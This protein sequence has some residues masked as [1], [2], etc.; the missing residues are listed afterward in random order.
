[1]RNGPK[2][3]NVAG[4]LGLIGHEQPKARLVVNRRVRIS[5]QAARRKIVGNQLL[6]PLLVIQCDHDLVGVDRSSVPLDA[7][8]LDALVHQSEFEHLIIL[9]DQEPVV[10]PAAR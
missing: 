1:M 8:I 10:D 9:I 3:S 6:D 5:L 4:F 7:A 2:A